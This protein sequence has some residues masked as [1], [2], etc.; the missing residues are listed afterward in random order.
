MTI[1]QIKIGF[2]NFSY[3]IHCKKTKKAAIVDPGYDANKLINLISNNNLE[4]EYIIATHYHH[5]HTNGIQQIKQTFSHVGSRNVIIQLH[6]VFISAA[7]FIF[8]LNI[9]KAM[10]NHLLHRQFIEV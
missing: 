3:I 9:G 4:L 7:E 8:G 5:D 10:Q 2:D 6:F 1:E